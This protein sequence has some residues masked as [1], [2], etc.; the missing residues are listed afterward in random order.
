M[1]V[2]VV[3]K[4]LGCIQPGILRFYININKDSNHTVVRFYKGFPLQWVVGGGAK[5]GGGTGRRDGVSGFLPLRREVWPVPFVGSLLLAATLIPSGLIFTVQ[6]A[7]L[8]S[9]AC[10]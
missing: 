9:A 7:A 3:S 6:A 4:Q 8:N 5:L 1:H 2:G 10:F